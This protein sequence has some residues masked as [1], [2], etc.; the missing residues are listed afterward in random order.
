MPRIAKEDNDFVSIEE[1]DAIFSN[2]V[3]D[4]RDQV[5]A[6]ISICRMFLTVADTDGDLEKAEAAVDVLEALLV[7]Q[8]KW[9]RDYNKE[10]QDL[11]KTH[12]KEFQSLPVK[13]R[14]RR[15]LTYKRKF[16]ISKFK[17]LVNNANQKGYTFVEEIQDE[18]IVRGPRGAPLHLP[19]EEGLDLEKEQY[20]KYEAKKD[21]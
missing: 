4:Y 11:K 19:Q 16:L 20:D 7:G 12:N 14:N 17:S 15:L 5:N 13:V 8:T 21:G 18:I 10:M 3:V 9:D 2:K 1:G 6:Q